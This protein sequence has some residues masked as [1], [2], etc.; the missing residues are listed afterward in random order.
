MCFIIG[1]VLV[2]LL[3]LYSILQLVWYLFLGIVFLAKILCLVTFLGFI[4]RKR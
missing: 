2:L 4:T 1:V 3:I